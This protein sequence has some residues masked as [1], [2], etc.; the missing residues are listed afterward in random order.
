MKK[1]LVFLV[2][3][4]MTFYLC[5][6]S[7]A[8]TLKE[9]NEE[10]RMI[11]EKVE[12]CNEYSLEKYMLPYWKGDVV[13]NE[14]IMPLKNDEGEMEPISLMY[15]IGAI[16]SVKSSRLNKTYEEGT[17]Y[18]LEDGKLKI[19]TSGSIPT[20]EYDYIYPTVQFATMNPDN[21]QHHRTKGY[22]YFAEGSAFH[23][24]Q[25]AVTYIPKGNWNGPV[26][27]QKSSFLPKTM[28]KLTN[29]EDIR[30][31]VYGDSISVGANSSKFVNVAPYCE[32][33]FEMVIN[34]LQK[35]Y[36][37]NITFENP[38][39]GGVASNWGVEN[40]KQLVADKGADLVII[41]FGMNDGSKGTNTITFKNNIEAI[42]NAVKNSNPN[43]EFV[44]VAPM[45][46]NEDWP[47]STMQSSYLEPLSELE[48]EGCAVAD[49]TSMHEYLLTRKRY[50]DM[51]GNHVNHPNDFLVRLYAQVIYEVFQTGE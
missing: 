17:D 43:C 32:N 23:Y 46:Q 16:V 4:A 3:A 26:P 9:D 19:L 47:T 39:V 41:A 38:S 29:G 48:K 5:A 35:Q 34:S 49:I 24:M 44:L 37:S 15:E 12:D 33:Y 22:M 51:T 7:L 2:L 30:I 21:V 40:V 1:F 36:G 31:V 25:L 27:T 45:L 8:K 13:Y 14:S 10:Y 6:C 42:M 18:V 28:E 11:A 20:I 50:I